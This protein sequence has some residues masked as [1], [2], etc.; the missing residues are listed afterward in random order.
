MTANVEKKVIPISL[1][2]LA[3]FIR[4]WH[5]GKPSIWMDEAFSVWVSSHNIHDI[6]TLLKMDTHPPG[7]Y[8]FLHEWF[9]FVGFN[10]FWLRF[11][12]AAMDAGS[13]VLIYW[14]VRE[15]SNRKVAVLS[16]LLWAASFYAQYMDTQVRMYPMAL[17][18]SLFST[19][20][21][22]KAFKRPTVWRWLVYL[23][24]AALSLYTHY[25]CG[26]IVMTHLF[27]MVIKKRIPEASFLLIGLTILFSPWIPGFLYQTHHFVGWRTLQV[28]PCWNLQFFA[29]LFGVSLIYGNPLM[30]AFANILGAIIM[31]VSGVV[32]F[33]N[34]SKEQ[35]LLWLLT[36]CPL[37]FLLI[38]YNFQISYVHW[39]RHITFLA[40]YFYFL[41]AFVLISLHRLFLVALLA[42][43]FSMNLYSSFLFGTG[44]AF[45]RQSWRTIS[46]YL[47][48][49]MQDGDSAWVEQSLSLFPIWYYDPKEFNIRVKTG[50]QGFSIEIL[51]LRH[52]IWGLGSSEV[53]EA[54][55]QAISKNS[56]RIWV[57]LCQETI[58]DPH[59]KVIRWF[60]KH[61][62]LLLAQRYRSLDEGEDIQVFLFNPPK[63]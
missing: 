23:I 57:I 59:E 55:L 4:L 31:A 30:I 58:A 2:A 13:A 42:C 49:H 25:Y 1:F 10:D 28:E 26:L 19:F 29:T 53:A 5:L 21:F 27:Y 35:G 54:Q 8:L 50:E 47:R 17:F 52:K 9:A 18:F 60:R 38:S 44:P 11:P 46:H 24:F 56:K 32:V 6:F 51:S 3:L 12:F 39:L 48:D 16:S 61:C 33:R 63:F 41:V 40:P 36:A 15:C 14:V 34:S 43:Y 37:S 62:P 45:E 7:F 20:F 22:L